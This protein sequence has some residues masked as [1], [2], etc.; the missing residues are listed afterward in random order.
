MEATKLALVAVKL[1][2]DNVEHKDAVVIPEDGRVRQYGA[3]FVPPL[4]IV[5]S[6]LGRMSEHTF[7]SQALNPL[8]RPISSS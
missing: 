6:R 1:E 5:K 8:I 7:S 2:A 3:L 4:R